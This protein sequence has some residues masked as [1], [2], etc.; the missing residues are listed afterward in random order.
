MYCVSSQLLCLFTLYS[1]LSFFCSLSQHTT[2]QLI[3]RLI[4]I[5][6]PII[7]SWKCNAQYRLMLQSYSTPLCSKSFPWSFRKGHKK[8]IIKK[9]FPT[10]EPIHKFISYDDFGHHIICN[11]FMYRNYVIDLFIFFSS[12][13]YCK[14]DSSN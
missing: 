6:T 1:F 10:L 13:K 12:I 7:A 3:A 9:N 2:T 8:G 4:R 5:K 14:W 11:L